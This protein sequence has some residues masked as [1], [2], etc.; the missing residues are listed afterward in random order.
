MR[1]MQIHFVEGRLWHMGRGDEGKWGG[2]VEGNQERHKDRLC[3]VLRFW[4]GGLFVFET[5]PGCSLSLYHYD[6]GGTTR[7]HT[8]PS[9][10]C[11]R[12]VTYLLCLRLCG[13]VLVCCTTF[14]RVL[15]LNFM[16]WPL[17]KIFGVWPEGSCFCFLFFFTYCVR[18]GAVIF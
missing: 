18:A 10:E 16:E 7:L 6:W 5:S 8:V 4:T 3:S 2:L 1:A 14:L 15:C 12:I 17:L 13:G 11:S 9:H